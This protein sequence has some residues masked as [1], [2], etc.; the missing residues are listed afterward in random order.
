M[1]E[2]S[3]KKI[4]SEKLLEKKLRETI[5]SRTGGLCVKLL[6]QNNRGFPDRLCLLPGGIVFFVEVKTT[7]KKPTRIQQI[8]HA[9]LQRLGFR[10]YILDSSQII[11]DILRFYGYE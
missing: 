6:P 7:G 4:E 8:I 11:D 10:V 5:E 1:Q 2:S 3:I 9:Q